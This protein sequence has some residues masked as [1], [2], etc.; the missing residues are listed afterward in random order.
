[1]PIH[2][3]L[4]AEGGYWVLATEGVLTLPEVE[5]LAERHDW[6]DVRNILWDLRN[7][8]EGPGTTEEL[9]AAVQMVGKVQQL[10]AGARVAILVSRDFDFGTAR[11]FQTFSHDQPVDYQ[12]FRERER[13]VAFLTGEASR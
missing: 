7:L 6:K 2:A 12:V 8:R 1:M 3:T 10:F 13:A 4:E 5:Q 11:M 9:R